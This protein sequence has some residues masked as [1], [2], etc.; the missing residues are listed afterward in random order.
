MSVNS[1][2]IQSNVGFGKQLFVYVCVCVVY[3]MD[4]CVFDMIHTM[5]QKSTD[6]NGWLIY[7]QA[8]K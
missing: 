8:Y 6:I 3:G 1:Y 4:A 2:K 7:V 5:R